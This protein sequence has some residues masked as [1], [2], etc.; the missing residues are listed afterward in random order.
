MIII[1]RR[2][3]LTFVT[4][5]TGPQKVGSSG[6]S[7]SGAAD[8]AHLVH[9]DD[10]VPPIITHFSHPI[11]WQPIKDLS[12]Q[13][14]IY[15]CFVLFDWFFPTGFLFARDLLATFHSRVK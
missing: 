6:H 3:L 7:H 10:N 9:L 13:V 12:F 5:T 1:A 4:S 14:A 15:H 8:D 11:C 2:S